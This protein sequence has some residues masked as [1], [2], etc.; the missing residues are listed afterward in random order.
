MRPQLLVLLAAAKASTWPAP[1]ADAVDAYVRDWAAGGTERRCGD[2]GAHGDCSWM[3]TPTCWLRAPEH[4]GWSQVW[5]AL[6]ATRDRRGRHHKLRARPPRFPRCNV[7]PEARPPPA[8]GA[9][10]PRRR[11]LDARRRLLKRISSLR[12]SYPIRIPIR[13]GQRHE[14]QWDTLRIIK[15]YYIYVSCTDTRRG[16]TNWTN[17]NAS[18]SGSPAARA[19]SAATAAPPA[20]SNHTALPLGGA[21]PA[22][23]L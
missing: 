4:P 21:S 13:G 2:V 10:P 6:P 1:P 23:T 11:V 18:C 3:T 17:E 20:E 16:R 7:Y 9:G 5:P 15:P 14:V 12:I 8:A 19:H 22:V